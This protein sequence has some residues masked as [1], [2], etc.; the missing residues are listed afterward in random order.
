MDIAL[1]LFSVCS[2][3]CAVYVM[4]EL[5]HSNRDLIKS[6]KLYNDASNELADGAKTLGQLHNDHATKVKAM[7]DRIVS[8]EFKI[9]SI[10]GGAMPPK[11]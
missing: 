8:L 2:L 6:M 1:L 7:E 3:G 4:V 10:T 5:K 9:Q 11:R